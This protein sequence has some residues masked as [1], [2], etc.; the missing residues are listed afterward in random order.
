M[1]IQ[2]I[3]S[4]RTRESTEGPF[5]TLYSSLLTEPDWFDN[6]QFYSQELIFPKTLTVMEE[7]LHRQIEHLG[8]QFSGTLVSLMLMVL[9]GIFILKKPLPCST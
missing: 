1:S 4:Y 7:L 6:L 5:V 2:V 8:F 3:F 9:H